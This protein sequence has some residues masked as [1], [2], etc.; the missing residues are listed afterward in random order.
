MIYFDLDLQPLVFHPQRAVVLDRYGFIFRGA[1]WGG[2]KWAHKIG[3][4]YVLLRY[5]QHFSVIAWY[6]TIIKPS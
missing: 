5:V 1:I 3:H 6:K 4:D 2:A